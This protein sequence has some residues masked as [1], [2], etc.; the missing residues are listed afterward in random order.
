MLRLRGRLNYLVHQRLLPEVGY[1]LCLP[2]F[3]LSEPL[4]EGLSIVQPAVGV[5]NLG[6]A[7]LLVADRSSNP[8]ED[9]NYKSSPKVTGCN[10]YHSRYRVVKGHA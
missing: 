2:R 5:K 8:W 6:Q 4:A 9:Y 1:G 10:P 3:H 7:P